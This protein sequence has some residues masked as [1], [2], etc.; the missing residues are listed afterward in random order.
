MVGE[1]VEP[2]FEECR[3]NLLFRSALGLLNLND[4]L[5]VPST[6]YLLRSRIVDWEN[7]GNENLI[8]KVFSQ[9]TKSQAIDFQVNG[10]R[11]VWTA[12]C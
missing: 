12:S 9:V 2:L 1:P 8:E 6:Y 5:P 10:K 7:E 4:P 11:F 3:F